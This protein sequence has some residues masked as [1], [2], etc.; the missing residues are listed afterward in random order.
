[1]ALESRSMYYEA[2]LSKNITGDNPEHHLAIRKT[3]DNQQTREVS[4]GMKF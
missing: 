2:R 4:K 1:M 3:V